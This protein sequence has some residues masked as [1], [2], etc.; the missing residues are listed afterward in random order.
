MRATFHI[1]VLGIM[2]TLLAPLITENHSRAEELESFPPVRRITHGPRHH[3]FGYYDK[4]QFDPTGRYVLGMEVPFEHRSPTADDVIKI[5]MVDLQDG[6]R[7]IELGQSTAW[8][9]QQGCM[10]QWL[11]GSKTKVLWNDP[12]GRSFCVPHPRREDGRRTNDS[13]CGLLGQSRRENC[14]HSRF[15]THSGRASRLRISRF[16]GPAC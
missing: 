4:L 10:L 5:G 12:R 13:A 6:D 3:W 11:P 14:G 2:V 7:W 15:P 8:C 1:L 16:A 9:W